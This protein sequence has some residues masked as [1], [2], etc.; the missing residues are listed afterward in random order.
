ML[1][2][3]DPAYDASKQRK[4]RV[5]QQQQPQGQKFNAVAACRQEGQQD[6]SRKRRKGS[7]FIH[8]EDSKLRSQYLA[9]M[10][11]AGIL[12]PSELQ[13]V[14]EQGADDIEAVKGMGIPQQLLRL[15][16]EKRQRAMQV[17]SEWFHAQDALMAHDE[18]EAE[19]M[20]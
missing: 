4:S 1:V 16:Q 14:R 6:T 11:A 15:Q 12:Q 5:Q 18:D 20:P 17:A 13:E 9:D 19:D 7:A 10:A 3:L 8:A 2:L